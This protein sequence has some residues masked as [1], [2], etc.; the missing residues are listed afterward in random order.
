M[1]LPPGHRGQSIGTA[2]IKRVADHLMAEG[3]RLLVVSTLESDE[4][5]RHI[6]QKLGFEK[7]VRMVHYS[8]ETP[9]K[10]S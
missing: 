8:L 5:A 6:Y 10:Q 1:P 7:H 2:L 3:A 4:P 9:D